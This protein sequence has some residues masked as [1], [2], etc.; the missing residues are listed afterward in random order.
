MLN[1]VN[2]VRN[3]LE[4]LRTE[5]AFSNILKNAEEKISDLNLAELEMPRKRKVPKRYEDSGINHL[6]GN[7]IE[8]FYRTQYFQ[9]IDTAISSLD[10]YFTSKHSNKLQTWTATTGFECT[11]ENKITN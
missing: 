10:Q 5:E 4:S 2:L 3:Q 1:A 7:S 9:V 6:S 8:E 11:L